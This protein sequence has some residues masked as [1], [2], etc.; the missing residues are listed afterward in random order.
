MV[1]KNRLHTR[2]KYICFNRKKGAINLHQYYIGTD[3]IQQVQEFKD[4]GIVFDEKLTF[5]PHID[6]LTTKMRSLYGAAYRFAREINNFP[7]IVKIVQT[8]I[9][10]VLEYGSIIWNQ[11]RKGCKCV[12]NAFF[13][14]R[15]V[16]LSVYLSIFDTSAT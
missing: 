9:T 2:T 13:T 5:I 16:L 12:L 14:S 10:P 4:L 3:R 1:H 7:S 15:L 8:Y 6:D 11:D